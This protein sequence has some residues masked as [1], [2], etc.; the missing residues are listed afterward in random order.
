MCKRDLRTSVTNKLTEEEFQE[1][2]KISQEIIFL[3]SPHTLEITKTNLPQK[4]GQEYELLRNNKGMKRTDVSDEMGMSISTLKGI[5]LGKKRSGGVTLRWY[6][7]YARYLGVPLSQIFLNAVERKE[8]E[9]R[10]RTDFW[11][12]FPRFRRLGD[13]A[14]SRSHQGTGDFM[15]AISA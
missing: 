9:L 8:D 12:V 1:V 2:L 5:E 13:G 11:K 14:S 3:L 4:L 15:S 7:K 10:I 6:F